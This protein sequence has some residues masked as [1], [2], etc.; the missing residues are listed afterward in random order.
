M[1]ST[2]SA[3]ILPLPGKS[4]LLFF[5][6]GLIGGGTLPRPGEVSLANNAVLFLDELPEFQRHVLDVLRQPLEDDEHC[7]N[8]IKSSEDKDLHPDCILSLDSGRYSCRKSGYLMAASTKQCH[9]DFKG[10]KGQD[11]TNPAMQ[12]SFAGGHNFIM[13]Y[14][15]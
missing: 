7:H 14:T 10:V 11:Q 9:V 12:A 6:A 2:P 13:L 1:I 8:Q 4:E 15:V 5:N 3:A